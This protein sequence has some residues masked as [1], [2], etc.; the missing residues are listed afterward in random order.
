MCFG[1]PFRLYYVL[2][3][4]EASKFKFKL[5]KFISVGTDSYNELANSDEKSLNFAGEKCESDEMSTNRFIKLNTLQ[6][7]KSKM[8][9]IFINVNHFFFIPTLNILPSIIACIK[10]I[11]GAIIPICAIRSPTGVR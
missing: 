11:S 9:N 10:Y 3:V 1:G 8:R 6:F 5:A 4:S 7:T 2:L